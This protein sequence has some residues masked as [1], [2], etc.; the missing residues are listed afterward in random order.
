MSAL[1]LNL[2]CQRCQVAEHLRVSRAKAYELIAAGEIPSIQVGGRVR[3]PADA[4]R[5]WIARR[6]AAA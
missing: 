6:L 4:L 5:E 1:E 3:V 2:I